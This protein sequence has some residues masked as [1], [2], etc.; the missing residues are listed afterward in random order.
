MFRR[1]VNV[2]ILLLSILWIRF[3]AAASQPFELHLLDVGQGQSVLIEADGHYMLF[4]GGGR[5]SS[6]FTV[7]YLKQQ[8]IESFDLV[9]VSHFDEDHMSGTIG[10][11][12]VFQIEQLL[13][14]S[15]E[16]EGDLY[17]SFTSAAVESG[18]D[19]LYPLAGDT[20]KLGDAD[21][22]VVGPIRTDYES[23]NDMSRALRISY[24]DLSC[25]ICGDAEWQSEMD[26]V[27]SGEEL[28]ADVYVV[29]HHGSKTSTTDK[30]LDTVAPAIA[31]ISCG[32]DNS[33]GHPAQ[34]TLQ[35]LQD[36]GIQMYRTDLQGTVVLSYD[37]S[38][39]WANQDPCQDWTPGIYRPSDT[40]QWVG[41]NRQPGSDQSADS[42][43]GNGDQQASEADTDYSYVCNTN[44][45]KFHYPD[46]SSVNQ[47]N[48]SNRLYTTLSRDEL[49]AQGYD[50]CGNCKP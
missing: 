48:E 42:G 17:Q 20:F 24:G 44:T 13:L 47:M 12:K 7:S 37:G 32:K 27:D 38:S 31:L 43:E 3:P 39:L 25:L 29:S 40:D 5:A 50:P 36:R 18:A 26:M 22:Q 19:I 6:S 33:Y 23:D 30:F 46:C 49:I 14:P 8:G 15:Y 11:L 28:S 16:G 10:V 35:R 4:D 1:A 21:I 45:R 41:I 34:E 2:I 9:A